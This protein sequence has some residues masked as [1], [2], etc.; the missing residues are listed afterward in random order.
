MKILK[1]AGH[2]KIL[3]IQP[4]LQNPQHIMEK[5]GRT[6]YQSYKG[7]I[8]DESSSKFVRMI[9]NRAHFSVI[10]PGYRGFII[11]ECGINFYRYFWPYTKFLFI[12]ERKNGN[13]LISGNMETWR[14]IYN[15]GLLNKSNLGILLNQY[16]PDVIKNPKKGNDFLGHPIT[17]I[18]QLASF[19]EFLM[20][21]SISVIFYLVCRGF[22]H[23]EVRHRLPAFSQESTRYVD[24]SEF[25][26]VVPPHKDENVWVDLGEGKGISMYGMFAE[27]EKFYRALR[28]AGYRP[29]DARQVLPIAIKAQI[30][31]SA[32][33]IAWV[34]MMIKRTTK[35][36]HWEIRR[37]F[38][39]LLLRLQKHENEQ[40]QRVFSD[41]R[42]A[43]KKDGI[44]YFEFV[45][46][47]E[48]Y[49]ML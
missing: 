38:G 22:T 21:V 30:V 8:T 28:K 29:E 1:D 34:W 25:R 18:E 45:G 39:N 32:P 46:D 16:C 5:A 2:S 14:K 9:I 6:C 10:E 11:P 13:I 48:K 12:T 47:L 44:R 27:I 40:I 19:E 31:T 26:V 17:A 4:G 37:V 7:K 36:A 42:V 35:P 20:H 33:L 3:T 23:E 41:F 49:P 43:G 15:K 24:E